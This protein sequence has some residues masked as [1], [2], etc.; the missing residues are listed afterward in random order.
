MENA[1]SA[2]GHEDAGRDRDEVARLNGGSRDEQHE[3]EAG[4]IP[5][6]FTVPSPVS[7]LMTA[8]TS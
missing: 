4:E 8:R 7:D 2:L 6:T 5:T 1:P 3:T